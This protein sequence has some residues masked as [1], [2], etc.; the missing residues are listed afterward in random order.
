LFTILFEADKIWK[1][2]K[3]EN[4]R[5]DAR[6]AEVIVWSVCIGIC[7]LLFA[8]GFPI[9]RWHAFGTLIAVPLLIARLVKLGKRL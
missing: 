8:I 3:R 6:N 9:E 1:K 5:E 2:R 4:D 7:A